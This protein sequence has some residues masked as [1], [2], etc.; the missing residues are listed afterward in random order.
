MLNSWNF[1]LVPYIK[2][3]N[4]QTCPA[5]T[6]ITTEE[7]CRDAL[8]YAH[9]LG[10]TLQSRKIWSVDL[11]HGYHFSAHFKVEEIKRFTSMQCKQ[12]TPEISLMASSR[13][14]AKKVKYKSWQEWKSTRN[15]YTIM[16]SNW[17]ILILK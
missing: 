3:G 4:L 2:L 16:F 8:G 11:G 9:D 17:Y 14:C 15:Y 12:P 10:I 7:L 13:W 1:K 5:G 6:E